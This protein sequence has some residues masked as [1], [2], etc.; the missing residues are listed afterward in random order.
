M[1]KSGSTRRA[2]LGLG[3]GALAAATVG[4]TPQWVGGDEDPYAPW[5]LWD[6]PELRDTPAA[7]V[8]AAMLAANPHDTQPWRF[9]VGLDA[10]EVYADLTRDLG[11]MDAALREMHLGLGCAIENMT[12]AASANGFAVDIL[13][14]PG[15]LP[16]LDAA[17]AP[18]LAATLRLSRAAATPHSLRAAL[19]ARHTNRYAYDPG[20]PPNRDWIDLAKA[21]G[22][23]AGVRVQL[24]ESGP[25]RQAFDA[26]VLDATEAIIADAQMIA[27]SDR[28][29][30][31]SAAEIATH[32]DGPTL[33]AAGLSPLKLTLAK[34]FPVSA[35]TS[36]RAWLDLTRDTQLA[37][38]PMV[39]LIVV[40]DRYDRPTALA[41]GRVWQRLHLEA[42]RRGLAMQPL[43]QPI[44]RIDRERQLG[45][46]PE[47]ERRVARLTEGGGQATFAFRVGYAATEAAASPRRR[48]ADVIMG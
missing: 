33:E 37:S 11:A 39:G 8:A 46:A 9:R 26:A 45:L 36:H 20:R 38:A 18:V 13:P 41:A 32:R 14:A 15:P 27:D 29:F 2:A 44:E 4:C 7:L 17:R 43:N 35:E 6:A 1:T 47:W 19:A 24:M 48:L 3:A 34:W 16:S 28:W 22:G 21:L 31:G 40:A 25:R 23:E 12:V 5:R 10:I 42:T 30:R